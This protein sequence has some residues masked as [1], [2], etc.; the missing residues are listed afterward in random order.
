MTKN[1]PKYPTHETASCFNCDGDF[2]GSYWS[3]SGYAPGR[4]EFL[5]SCR[6]CGMST[7]YDLTKKAA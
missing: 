5:Q 6:K 3:K 4:G 2:D 1:F 7:W